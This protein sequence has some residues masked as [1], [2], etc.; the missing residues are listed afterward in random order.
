MRILFILL[1]FLMFAGVL[2]FVA[3]NLETEVP[4]KMFRTAHADVPLYLVVILSVFFGIVYAGILAVAEG[5]HIRLANRRMAREIRKLETEINYLRTQPTVSRSEPDSLAGVAS[6]GKPTGA[7]RRS[8]ASR[9]LPSAPVY[10]DSDD[11][12]DDDDDMYSGGHAV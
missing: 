10:G 4:V 5:A 8:E 11:P 6:P 9:D 1:T 2:G 12:S 3:D 7:D